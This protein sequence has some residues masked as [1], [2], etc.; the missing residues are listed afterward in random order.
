MCS[1]FVCVC[2]DRAARREAGVLQAQKRLEW[3]NVRFRTEI[4][5]SSS[6]QKRSLCSK[7]TAEWTRAQNLEAQ[8]G[9]VMGIVTSA[10]CFASATNAYYRQAFARVSAG[11]YR[12]PSARQAR[13]RA[14]E[15]HAMV[16]AERPDW[17]RRLSPWWLAHDAATSTNSHQMANFVA[18]S[19]TSTVVLLACKEVAWLSKS[20]ARTAEWLGRVVQ[21]SLGWPHLAGV[22]TDGCAAMKKALRVFS[23]KA[24]TQARY[25]VTNTCGEHA[26][27]RAALDLDK[28]VPWLHFERGSAQKVAV[29]LKRRKQ[30][31]RLLAS[32]QAQAKGTGVLNHHVKLKAA[33]RTRPYREVQ[34]SVAQHFALLA[35]F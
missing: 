9:H 30:A 15:L 6:P 26:G 4:A 18:V 35:Y 11:R 8:L 3:L 20:G 28:A 19:A 14:K 29:F 21:N 5:I 12:A 17:I 27:D 22:V 31:A 24:L 34:G 25:A 33:R 13:E 1:C 32:R 10:G 2:C 23:E 16:A 7:D